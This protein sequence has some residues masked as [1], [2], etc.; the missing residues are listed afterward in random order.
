MG[1]IRDNTTQEGGQISEELVAL[2][3]KDHSLTYRVVAGDIPMKDY[4]STLSIH[5]VAED[6]RAFAIWTASY[7]PFGNAEETA[8]WVRNGIFQTCL[9]N[10]EK[11]LARG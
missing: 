1:A 10:L 4:T 11:V 8:D 6:G 7:E 9:A 3:N 5:E 2:S